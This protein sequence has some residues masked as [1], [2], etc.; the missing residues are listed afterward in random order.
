M[1]IEFIKDQIQKS[2]II[3]AIGDTERAI[4][5]AFS[6]MGRKSVL[7]H[8]AAP[9]FAK[10][11]LFG[12][13][14]EESIICGAFSWLFGI[15]LKAVRAVYD[16]FDHAPVLRIIPRIADWILSLRFSDVCAVLAALM[17]CI[18]HDNWNNGY[19]FVISVLLAILYLIKLTKSQEKKSRL[20][21]SLYLFMLI[22]AAIIPVAGNMSANVRVYTYFISAFSFFFC[23]AGSV[24]NI[25]DL[26][27]VLMILYIAVLFNSFLAIIQGYYGTNRK[28]EGN[29]R[30]ARICQHKRKQRENEA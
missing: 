6:R 25:D 16:A 3:G 27:R 24:D 18:Y 20:P 8:A 22:S 21:V 29:P 17:L 28:R 2:Q 14:R 5:G 1:I 23:I 26:R 9:A 13:Q 12:R 19:M 11:D 15:L 7:V 30:R 4:Y 10:R